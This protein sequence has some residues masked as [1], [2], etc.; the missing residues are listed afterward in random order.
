MQVSSLE[1]CKKLAGK[2]SYL[3]ELLQDGWIPPVKEREKCQLRAR[4]GRSV[5][6]TEDLHV[7]TVRVLL[8]QEKRWACVEISRELGIAES[9]VHT[10]LRKKLNM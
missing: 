1:H 5:A 10:I 7:H 6:A 3:I 8:E 4:A 9:T 2:I